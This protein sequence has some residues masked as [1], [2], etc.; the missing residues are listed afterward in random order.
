MKYSPDEEQIKFWFY[1]VKNTQISKKR[2]LRMKIF[3]RVLDFWEL[4]LDLKYGH[5]EKY[6]Y[7]MNEFERILYVLSN[8]FPLSAIWFG[9]FERVHRSWRGY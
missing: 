1:H 4:I 3:S 6:L 8:N 2:K 5:T 7:R 9:F